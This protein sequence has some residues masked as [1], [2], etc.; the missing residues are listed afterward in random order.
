[1]SPGTP[2][3]GRCRGL[4]VAPYTAAMGKRITFDHEQ[5]LDTAM[6]T[7][8]KGGYSTTGVRDLMKAIGIGEGSFYNTL[9]SKKDLYLAALQHYEDTVLQPRFDALEAA[10][11]AGQGIRALLTVGLDQLDAGQ[12]ASRLCMVAGMASEDVLEDPMLAARARGGFETLRQAVQA[13]LQRGADSGQLPP[14]YDVQAVAAVVAT[15]VQG[16]WRTLLLDPD[17]ARIERQNE[18]LLAAL[19]L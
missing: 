2:A 13:R 11:T 18:T 3:D 8:W 14:G 9:K 7:F 16:M 12:A 4:R 19:G 5:A 17:R 15:Y 6:R 10:A 1:M